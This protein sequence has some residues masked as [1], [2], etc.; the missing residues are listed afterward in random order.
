MNSWLRCFAC[1]EDYREAT[2]FKN[3]DTG[4]TGEV[5][6]VKSDGE[7]YNLCPKCMRLFFMTLHMAEGS[8][9]PYWPEAME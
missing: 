1:G 5:R 3:I 7:S 4:K 6:A 8:D 9:F 2:R